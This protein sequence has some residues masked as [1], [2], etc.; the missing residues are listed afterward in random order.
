MGKLELTDDQLVALLN[1]QFGEPHLPSGF[2]QAEV[3]VDG[4]YLQIGPRVIHFSLKGIV[5]SA[6]QD[7]GQPLVAVEM[8][9]S[10]RRGN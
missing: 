10:G 6:S 2:V 3:T 4:I 5:R 7:E 1:Q 8:P 9:I